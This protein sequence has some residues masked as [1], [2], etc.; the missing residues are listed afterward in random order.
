MIGEMLGLVKKLIDEAPGMISLDEIPDFA[1]VV[2]GYD[3]VP[4]KA[5]RPHRP[6]HQR[7]SEKMRDG[8]GHQHR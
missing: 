2:K 1:N 8:F 6:L 5:D 7:G 3:A 4:G